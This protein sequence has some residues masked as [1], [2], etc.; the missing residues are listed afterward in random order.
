MKHISLF[1]LLILISTSYKLAAQQ[2]K[3]SFGSFELPVHIFEK[4]SKSKQNIKK[5]IYRFDTRDS[6]IFFASDKQEKF[7]SLVYISDRNARSNRW[8][9]YDTSGLFR[10]QIIQRP[11]GRE[12]KKVFSNYY[13]ENDSL[14][15]KSNDN[16]SLDP[17]NLLIESNRYKTIAEVYLNNHQGSGQQ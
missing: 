10:V 2:G 15:H 8:Y 6:S 3:S 16:A 7:L 5:I 4:M 12:V 9:Y 13:F 1:A 14:I 17:D 11:K